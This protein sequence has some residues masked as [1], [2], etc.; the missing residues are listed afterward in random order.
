MS[1]KVLVII[2]IVSVAINLATVVTLGFRWLSDTRP[3][4]FMHRPY[5]RRAEVCHHILAREIGLEKA[6]VEQLNKMRE[7]MSGIMQPIQREIMLR[8]HELI[9]LL[10]QAD[11]DT[12]RAAELLK[13]ISLLQTEHE[14]RAF[15]VFMRVKEILTPEQQARLES[16]M[17]V[18]IEQCPMPD[19]PC[20][21][22]PPGPTPPPAQV[23]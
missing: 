22:P 14:R 21:P 15:D 12:A 19:R 10:K 20:P 13:E 17:N 7:E 11:P 1:N 16:I 2:L 23:K 8:R 4:P 6:Q 9:S 3:T 5:E 18:F